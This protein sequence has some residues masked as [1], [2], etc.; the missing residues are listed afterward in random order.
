MGL[1][2]LEMR[3]ETTGAPGTFAGPA[4]GFATKTLYPPAISF[5]VDPSVAMLMRDDEMRQQNEPLRFNPETFDPTW[6]FES[7]LYPDTIAFLLNLISPVTTTAG[8]GVITDLS[9]AVVPAGA[10]RHDFT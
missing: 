4:S 6:T 8:D 2:I 5:E 1:S 10:Y 3:R 7:R 9:G